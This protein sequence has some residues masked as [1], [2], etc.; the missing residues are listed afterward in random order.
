M[1]FSND[2][3]VEKIEKRID[4]LEKLVDRK[5]SQVEASFKL[6]RDVIVKL[7]TEKEALRKER[8]SLIEKQK[9]ILKKIPVSESLHERITEP[10]RNEIRENAKLIRKIAEEDVKLSRRGYH[11]R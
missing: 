3:K 4:K 9:D 5:F 10:V 8:D 1:L 6:F 2:E 7:Q 11:G